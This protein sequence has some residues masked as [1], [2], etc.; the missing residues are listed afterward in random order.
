[1]NKVTII[2][3]GPGNPEFMTAAAAEALKACDVICG[4]TVYVDLLTPY[5]PEKEVF[6]TKMT[7]EVDRCKWALDEA[8]KGRHIALVCSG[9]AGVYGMSG[10]L[11]ELSTDYPDVEVE[12]VAGITA[13]LSGGAVL[14]APLTQDF[15][16]LSLSDWLTPM[17]LIKK[18]LE[19]AAIGDFAMAI[20]N[21]RSNARPDYLKEACEILLKHR[22]P[23]T[24]CGWVRNIGRDGEEYKVTT[25]AEL[26]AHDDEVDM[27]TTVFVGS[28]TTKNVNGKMVTP[29]G[30]LQR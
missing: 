4:Y 17:D 18:R 26:M 9:D 28:S 14:G 27:F 12:V 16:V 15:V 23:D 3:M 5:Y 20:Y 25:L 21:P 6:S 30:Y 29:R 7:K 13:A 24:V 1:M 8:K 19:C 2:G 22:S 11:Y 10:L